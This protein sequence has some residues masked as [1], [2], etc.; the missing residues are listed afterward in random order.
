MTVH[1]S[2]CLQ[3]V[4]VAPPGS[5]A[6]GF[7][8]D[9]GTRPREPVVAMSRLGRRGGTGGAGAC[10]T[11]ESREGGPGPAGRPDG[12]RPARGTDGTPACRTAPV[13]VTITTSSSPRQ[14]S[15]LRPPTFFPP[16][17][18]DIEG[19]MVG[20]ARSDCAS[21][22]AA[23]G[24]GSRPASSRTKPGSRSCSSASGP[25]TRQRRSE[26]VRPGPRLGSPRAPPST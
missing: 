14:S 16:S 18:P 11:R 6:S 13:A 15:R 7:P 17:H 4:A 8:A 25:A 22:T 19:R 23:V 12:R 5:V 1:V 2:Y 10:S 3:G 26:G 9:A 21:M 20:A 24:S